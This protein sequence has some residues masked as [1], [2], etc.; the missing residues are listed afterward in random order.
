MNKET[1]DKAHIEV[2]RAVKEKVEQ[3]EDTSNRSEKSPSPP[4]VELKV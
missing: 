3:E 4:P 2:E 1:E